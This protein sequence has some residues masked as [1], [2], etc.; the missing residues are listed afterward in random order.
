MLIGKKL[1]ANS[2]EVLAGCSESENSSR[3]NFH[4]NIVGP[5]ELASVGRCICLLSMFS[6]STNW[7]SLS[8][9]VFVRVLV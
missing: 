4:V 9:S 7:Y 5:L 2:H 3:R 6:V 1:T 8:V